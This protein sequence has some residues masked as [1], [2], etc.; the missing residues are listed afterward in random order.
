NSGPVEVRADGGGVQN[1][2]Y[3][4]IRREATAAVAQIEDAVEGHEVQEVLVENTANAGDAPDRGRTGLE[5][6]PFGPVTKEKM[7]H[8]LL[9]YIGYTGAALE[10]VI[11]SSAWLIGL[12]AASIAGGPGGFLAYLLATGAIWAIFFS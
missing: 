7:G 9:R 3:E 6:S 5:R 12:A 2:D 8:R 4:R 11:L 10:V 1:A